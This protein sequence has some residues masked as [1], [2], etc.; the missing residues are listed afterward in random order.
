ME[1]IIIGLIGFGA[2]IGCCGILK[3]LSLLCC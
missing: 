2:G 3:I 1:E